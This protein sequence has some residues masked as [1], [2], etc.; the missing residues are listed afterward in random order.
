MLNVLI[1]GIFLFS[2]VTSVLNGT[3]EPL[4]NELLAAPQ[5]AFEL[6]LSVGF[7]LCLWSGVMEVAR[8]A[9]LLRA[10]SA[11]FRP[12]LSLLFPQLKPDSPA[13][14]AICTNLAANLLGLGAAAAPAGIQAVQEMQA[15]CPD[16]A[17]ASPSSILLNTPSLQLIPT[18]AAVLRLQAGSA[19]PMEILPAVWVTS[20]LSVMV[21]ILAAKLIERLACSVSCPRTKEEAL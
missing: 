7:G 17:V 10:V 9:G 19:A 15:L 14:Q 6:A 1:S 16:P 11:L 2:L 8:Q 18:T 13:A 4:C 3:T 21:G 12:V 5:K 20:L